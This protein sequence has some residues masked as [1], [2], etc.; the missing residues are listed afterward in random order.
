MA[1]QELST[2]LFLLLASD[3]L[4]LEPKELFSLS[5]A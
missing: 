2:M 1:F 3:R 4:C 5:A